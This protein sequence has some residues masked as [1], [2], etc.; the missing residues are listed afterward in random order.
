MVMV[1]TSLVW[2][3]FCK[4]RASSAGKFPARPLGYN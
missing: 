1:P 2:A 4:S 3:L